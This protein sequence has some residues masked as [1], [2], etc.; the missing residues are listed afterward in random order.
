MS[1]FNKKTLVAAV[2]VALLVSACGG[3]GGAAGSASS[4]TSTSSLTVAP[5]LGQ[6]AAG[7]KVFLKDHKGLTVTS[8]TIGSDGMV[9]LT[10]DPAKLGAEVFV[11]QVGDGTTFKYFNEATGQDEDYTGTL[12]STAM[13]SSSNQTV[14]VSALTEMA[15]Q[16]V[17]TELPTLAATE[18]KTRITTEQKQ[19]AKLFLGSEEFD[20]TRAPAI[21]GKNTTGL[22]TGD[23]ATYAATL[24]AFAKAAKDAGQSLDQVIK[25]TADDYKD[26]QTI[27]AGNNDGKVAPS[28][29][30]AAIPKLDKLPEAITAAIKT[31]LK[32][33]EAKAKDGLSTE[34]KS[35]IKE[36]A[37]N[38][39]VQNS[40]EGKN[41][42]ASAKLLLNDLRANLDGLEQA[43]VT[44]DMEKQ[45]NLAVL[46]E[47]SA[48]V[49]HVGVSIHML[50]TALNIIAG[51]QALESYQETYEDGS[52][53]SLMGMS[54]NK[55]WCDSGKGYHNNY[56]A[57][58]LQPTVQVARDGNGFWTSDKI[59]VCQ[60]TFPTGQWLNQLPLYKRVYIL[61]EETSTGNYAWQSYIRLSYKPKGS[62]DWVSIARYPKDTGTGT[63][64][65]PGKYATSA[66]AKGSLGFINNYLPSTKLDLGFTV[67][68]AAGNASMRGSISANY[69]DKV[70]V[71][72]YVE[73]SW[74]A[75]SYQDVDLSYDS[76]TDGELPGRI[77]TLAGA[78]KAFS[79]SLDNA[80]IQFKANSNHP[81]DISKFTMAGS[82]QAG[83]VQW[84][85]KELTM[86]EPVNWGN[87][88][89]PDI[90]PQH[91][92]FHGSFLMNN[93][94]V[95][96][97]KF[98]ARQDRNGM[99]PL[100]ALSAS[101][102]AKTSGSFLGTVMAASRP[103]E[104]NVSYQQTA[105]EDF[106][107]AL[108]YKY[109]NAAGRTVQL[110]GNGSWVDDV[111]TFSVNSAGGTQIIYK[112]VA[113]KGV[114]GEI[115]SKGGLLIGRLYKGRA[116]FVDGTSVSLG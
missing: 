112:A 35:A 107:L 76:R 114:I 73:K 110:T 88:A 89:N 75:A 2:G 10:Y 16:A 98:E 91:A 33:V 39:V 48:A 52:V 34:D 72:K 109:T 47:G 43:V 22:G 94:L 77:K 70:L 95:F 106:T 5:S 61:L 80:A 84:K 40:E 57:A 1:T 105:Y 90:R 7:T 6:I 101:N 13:V 51:K 15:Y 56:P 58:I 97:G 54:N 71:E 93:Q 64:S 68:Q 60:A 25:N 100:K 67:D 53:Y 32:D 9:T 12:S 29:V 55:F 38:T 108:G 20:I 23:A 79:L 115:R 104:V 87:D 85:L 26:D 111:E 8:G 28:E 3:G 41:A 27:S 18:L 42:V 83:D 62:T 50:S 36:A 81:N 31:Q 74:Q 45:M 96:D 86:D 59:A 103:L 24:A 46:P 113:E 44:S 78:G 17:A 37:N 82:M 14:G 49:E 99:D 66:T 21:L 30:L 65:F 63:Y 4:S 69:Q 102:Y 116:E 92:V 11:V 19:V